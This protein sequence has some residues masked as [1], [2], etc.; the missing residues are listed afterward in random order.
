MSDSVSTYIKHAR[1]ARRARRR[2]LK[3]RRVANLLEARVVQLFSFPP[4]AKDKVYDEGRYQAKADK[5][6]Y[7]PPNNC[8]CIVSGARIATTATSGG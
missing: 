4:M 2:R 5:S 8:R 3:E 7:Y 6:S 1:R